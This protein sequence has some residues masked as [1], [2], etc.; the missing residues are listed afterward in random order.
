MNLKS[1]TICFIILS[2]VGDF[3][4]R[5]QDTVTDEYLIVRESYGHTGRKITT[6]WTS[7]IN[8]ATV[9]PIMYSNNFLQKTYIT[10]STRRVPI[11]VIREV[12]IKK[13]LE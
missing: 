7:D 6:Y 10:N 11:E 4:G 3:H 5:I 13:P 12:R 1:I 9:F 8:Q 2:L